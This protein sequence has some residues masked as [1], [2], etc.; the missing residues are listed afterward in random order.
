MELIKAKKDNIQTCYEKISLY[1]SSVNSSVHYTK[2]Y[3]LGEK[4]FEPIL[5]NFSEYLESLKCDE[6]H[7][8]LSYSIQGNEPKIFYCDCTK[9]SWNLIEKPSK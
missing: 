5:K 1:M 2:W 9:I 3:Q 6:C 7:N 8:Y 4:D